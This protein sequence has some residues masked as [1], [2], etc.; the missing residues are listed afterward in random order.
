MEK[1]VKNVECPS[2]GGYGDHGI[3]EDTGFLYIC[4][5]CGGMGY[6]P[7]DELTDEDFGVED[8]RGYEQD[9]YDM[10]AIAYGEM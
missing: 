10:D 1:Q 9:C 3:E 4:Y 8:D 6:V 5:R 2:C 7:A